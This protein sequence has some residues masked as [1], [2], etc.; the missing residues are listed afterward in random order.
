VERRGYNRAAVAL[1]NKHTRVIQSLLISD[2][3]YV[4]PGAA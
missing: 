3:E 2:R 4:R 1:A